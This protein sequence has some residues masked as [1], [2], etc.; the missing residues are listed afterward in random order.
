MA[1]KEKKQ[2]KE[3][4]VKKGFNWDGITQ[5][6]KSFDEKIKKYDYLQFLSFEKTYALMAIKVVYWIGILALLVN[7]MVALLTAS[8]L[9]GF[10]ITLIC[11]PLSLLGLR[12][13][14][15][16]LMVW[17][18]IYERLGEIKKELAKK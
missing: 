10:L 5:K 13:V 7:F 8:S 2:K 18:G 4:E 12:V 9:T 16:L 1:E 6:I 15:E 3:A 11:I 17:F 14:C